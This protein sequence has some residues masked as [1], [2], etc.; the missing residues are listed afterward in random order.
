[1]VREAVDEAT[2]YGVKSSPSFFVNGRLAPEP[3]PFL[4]PFDFFKRII[5]EELSRQVRRP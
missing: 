1:M 5:E 4:P 2:R 3:P